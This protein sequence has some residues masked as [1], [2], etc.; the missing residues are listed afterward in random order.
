MKNFRLAQIVFLLIILC[1]IVG[2]GIYYPQLPERVA[3]HFGADGRPNGWQ[4]KSM[5]TTFFY[6]AMGIAAVVGFLVPLLLGALSPTMINLP[7]KDY[8]LAPERRE[9]SVHFLQD[10][11][12]WFGCAVL[13]LLCFAMYS[14]IQANLTP[15]PTMDPTTFFIALGAFVAFAIYSAVRMFS[16]FAKPQGA[17][18]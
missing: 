15:N 1:A 11:M 10:Q 6:G 3:S 2:Y 4:S 14:A 17:Q 13:L 18:K 8:W 5:F 16:R 12:T 9:N 7:N